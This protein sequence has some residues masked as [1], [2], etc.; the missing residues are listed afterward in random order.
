MIY[1]KQA[2]ILLVINMVILRGQ[3][4]MRTPQRSVLFHGNSMESP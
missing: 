1:S 3:K 2:K 4:R